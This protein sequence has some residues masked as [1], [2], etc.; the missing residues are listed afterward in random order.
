MAE[1]TQS[2]LGD[3]NFAVVCFYLQ[4]FGPHLGLPELNLQ[5]LRSSIEAK[6]LGSNFLRDLHLSLLRKLGKKSISGGRWEKCVE[7]FAISCC[8]VDGWYL[9]QHGYWELRLADKVVIL[10]NLLE[11]QFDSN[12]KFKEKLNEIPAEELRQQPIGYDVDGQAYW[13]LIDSEMNVGVFRG[14]Q[15]DADGETWEVVS[16]ERADLAQLIEDLKKTAGGGHVADGSKPEAAAAAA[17]A[18]GDA[19]GPNGGVDAPAV[20]YASCS[21][22]VKAVELETVN[23]QQQPCG[24]A[25]DMKS[26]R[27]TC[28]ADG[29]PRPIKCESSSAAE[30]AGCSAINS[31]ACTAQQS[32][33]AVATVKHEAGEPQAATPVAA[34]PD[35]A[36]IAGDASD[37]ASDCSSDNVPLSQVRK[38]CRLLSRARAAIAEV[39]KRRDRDKIKKTKK[40][41]KP[42]AKSPRQQNKKKPIKAPKES[43]SSEEAECNLDDDE[44]DMGESGGSENSSDV[45]YM[46]HG[47]NAQRAA[48]RKAA[49]AAGSSSVAAGSAA[50]AS[51]C[52]VNDDTP[53]T[54]C[55]DYTHP[56]LILLCDR[57]NAGFHTGCLRPPLFL[58]PDGDWFCPHCEHNMLIGKLEAALTDYDA[59]MK[60]K[61]RAVKRQERMAHSGISL[62]NIIVSYEE[63]PKRDRVQ[64]RSR[65]DDYEYEV[66]ED[67]EDRPTRPKTGPQVKRSCRMRSKVSYRYEEYDELIKS[68]IAD[69]AGPQNEGEGMTDN[70]GADDGDDGH[71]DA[72]RSGSGGRKGGGKDMATIM[73]ANQASHCDSAMPP[74]PVSR[75]KDMSTILGADD[76]DESGS[77]SEEEEEEG[78]S[79]GS[80]ARCPRAVLPKKKKSRKL[81]GLDD[82]AS[83]D[84]AS[85]EY[86]A[87]DDDEYDEDDDDAEEEAESYDSEANSGGSSPGSWCASRRR[88]GM[89]PERRATR[90][91]PER[92]TKATGR[93]YAGLDDSG[94]DREEATSRRRSVRPQRRAVT[95]RVQIAESDD[96]EEAD[97]AG[98]GSGGG[99]RRKRAASSDY[100]GGASDGDGGDGH[101]GDGQSSDSEDGHRLQIVNKWNKRTAAPRSGVQKGR[102]I[103]RAVVE[104]EEEEEDDDEASAAAEKERTDGEENGGSKS[105]S[106]C[107]N[108]GDGDGEPGATGD[109][110]V[111]DGSTERRVAAAEMAPTRTAPSDDSQQSSRDGS[112]SSSSSSSGQPSHGASSQDGESDKPPPGV[113]AVC[114]QADAA[115]S[116]R[117]GLYADPTAGAHLQAISGDG[118]PSPAA[119]SHE[120]AELAGSQTGSIAARRSS[121]DRQTD[122]LAAA[123]RVPAH[124]SECTAATAQ[125]STD[126]D[127]A[128]APAVASRTNGTVDSGRLPASSPPTTTKSKA[129]H[130]KSTSSASKSKKARYG[131]PSS[132]AATE[133]N[134]SPP[135][136]A[137]VIEAGLP[138][139]LH[140]REPGHRHGPVSGSALRPDEH[141][142]QSAGGDMPSAGPAKDAGVS[143][144][145]VRAS[146]DGK[147][148][149]RYGSPDVQDIGGG[150]VEPQVYTI[151]QRPLPPQPMQQH[152]HAYA[153]A[154]Q[155]S[156]HAYYGP[157]PL[158]GGYAGPG[159]PGYGMSAGAA[160]YVQAYYPGLPAQ[161]QQQSAPPAYGANL[162]GYSGSM[163]AQQRYPATVATMDKGIPAVMCNPASSGGQLPAGGHMSAAAAAA[164]ARA[165]MPSD[166]SQ[167]S[168]H[169]SFMID[170][171]LQSPQKAAPTA[172]TGAEENE[173]ELS[174]ILD[175]VSYVTG[176]PVGDDRAHKS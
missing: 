56:D 142:T 171:I 75:G 149:S 115:A 143:A 159:L 97:V 127:A 144:G 31:A 48:R 79:S 100:S 103:R 33:R 41:Q 19:D 49:A 77:G 52:V 157:S 60:V 98:G 169:A 121:A 66:E 59:K 131:S 161:L 164:T 44:Y 29:S 83:E 163:Y 167:N 61:Q 7:Q 36:S 151:N 34:A 136:S 82:S 88:R 17:P 126:A 139:R 13:F 173:D 114:P 20:A 91:Q 23:Q 51:E 147:P 113:E 87:T 175:I 32:P 150:R 129:Q 111:G 64:K 158:Y 101:E 38:S 122:A 140:Q 118:S 6:K 93:K 112:S 18:A 30:Q 174:N 128:P 72:R 76:D 2:C 146:E 78:S 15:D 107:D 21:A 109:R 57:C 148:R 35:A 162:G 14:E 104:S 165:T 58:I 125:P 73:L 92:A 153:A 160:P 170:N 99:R 47:R 67:L 24:L 4:K 50:S 46:P 45:D 124:D 65:N 117:A 12:T 132:S 166:R 53:C 119:A 81:T 42:P 26:G 155:S 54:R 27:D 90:S 11:A 43:E 130:V 120:A 102:R 123:A 106:E 168:H 63:R 133:Q 145:A 156:H 74:A 10:K 68:A 137:G 89:R 25:L 94:S 40:L 5:Q 96:E 138:S 1:T 116:P 55:G 85:D 8:C 86:K 69:S 152:Q 16:R 84:D 37:A 70:H 39:K 176:A 71:C 28:A 135:V 172:A 134:R 22:E 95:R 80:A 105:A 9:S 154:R 141:V 108:S 110:G 62:D 3:P